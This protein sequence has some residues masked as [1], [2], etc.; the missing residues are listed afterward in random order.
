MRP[1]RMFL[2]LFERPSERFAQRR[3]HFEVSEVPRVELRFE[4]RHVRVERRPRA[5]HLLARDRG[6]V[7]RVHRLR[8]VMRLVEH[9]H[10][11]P[12]PEPE[13]AASLRVE[14]A[15][16]TARRR[17]PREGARA[18]A[19]NTDTR[20][21]E[22]P[23]LARSSMSVGAD[24]S[25]SASA[26]TRAT[27]TFQK[28]TP[29]ETIGWFRPGFFVAALELPELRAV[30]RKRPRAAPRVFVAARPL[31]PLRRALALT[32]AALLREFQASLVEPRGVPAA[33]RER[34]RVDAQLFPP[35]HRD[36]VDGALRTAETR[37]VELA[38][39]LRQL[40]VR[41]AAEHHLRRRAVRVR[42]RTLV[43]V[44]V[45]IP[46]HAPERAL[47]RNLRKPR[48]RTAGGA[49]AAGVVGIRIRIRTKRRLEASEPVARG[50]RDRVV[51]PLV[52]AK[53]RLLDGVLAARA[54][55]ESR[56]VRRHR[57][58]LRRGTLTRDSIPSAAPPPPP[59]PLRLANANPA[60][61]P[62][63]NADAPLSAGAAGAFAS[64]KAR[65]ASA[66]RRRAA[67]LRSTRRAA[68]SA[69]RD[70]RASRA[71]S[72][73]QSERRTPPPRPGVG[74]ELPALGSRAVVL[75]AWCAR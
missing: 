69:A 40:R 4:P 59:P 65:S 70:A 1:R 16:R 47:L 23:R 9:N 31:R 63:P 6:A 32:L 33:P 49:A 27:P 25:S 57:R 17:G 68:R 11:A 20:A 46:E 45:R 66:A 58:T 50:R 42:V 52:R 30:L 7:R 37:R 26:S 29:G 13:R 15:S 67:A 39:H 64:K 22:R 62:P 10:R 24:R 43:L 2:R 36:G 48:G 73:S 35:G 38:D 61:P 44:H 12:Q 18:R 8:E 54:A 75:R 74:V 19:R 3:E 71:W 51:A 28:G 55:S 21:A 34:V 60:A 56:R 72:R 41:P 53:L 5:P 14:H